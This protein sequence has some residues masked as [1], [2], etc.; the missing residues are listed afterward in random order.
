MKKIKCPICEQVELALVAKTGRTMK[1]RV[2]PAVAIPED[3]ELPECGNCGA[4][5]IDWR[6]AKRLDAV[7]EAAYGRALVERT[8][9]ALGR[10][11]AVKPLREWEALLGLSAGYLSKVKGDAVPSAQLTGLLWLLANEPARAEELREVWSDQWRA[12]AWAGEVRHVQTTQVE[13]VP[14]KPQT[15]QSF[16]YVQEIAAAA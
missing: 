6:T 12:L 7:L 14:P 8:E 16:E 9:V 4:A 5:P 13:A 15:V 3:F 2:L 1:H 10:L 11:K